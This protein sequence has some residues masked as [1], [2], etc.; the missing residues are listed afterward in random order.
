MDHGVEK[1]VAWDLGKNSWTIFCFMGPYINLAHRRAH[2]FAKL[3][4]NKRFC[5]H[6]NRGIIINSIWSS[7]LHN[8]LL[9]GSRQ[10]PGPQGSTKFANARLPGLT[11]QLGKCSAVARGG[12]GGTAGIKRCIKRQ[13]HRNNCGMHFGLSSL[14]VSK[15]SY[16]NWRRSISKNIYFSPSK[17]EC[18]CV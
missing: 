1:K 11:R 15:V 12:G 17:A 18:T 16:K 2:T 3:K 14:L 9:R 6:Y 5:Y 13:N 4:L 10:M 8:R 7:W